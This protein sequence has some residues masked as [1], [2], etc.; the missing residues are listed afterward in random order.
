M[1]QIFTTVECRIS[2]RLKWYKNYKNRLR[3]AKVIVKNKMSRFMVQFVYIMC[4]RFRWIKICE[5]DLQTP[6]A[7]EQGAHWSSNNQSCRTRVLDSDSSGTRVRFLADLDLDLVVKDSDLDITCLQTTAEALSVHPEMNSINIIITAPALLWRFVILTPDRN[8]LTYL[9]TYLEAE[10]LD[11][12]T[13]MILSKICLYCMFYRV[14]A[15][16]GR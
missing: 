5:A 9:L 6:I 11:L 13:E 3:L 7:C 10:D 1:W 2:S 14:L 16:G 12:N 15:F 4:Y 8:C